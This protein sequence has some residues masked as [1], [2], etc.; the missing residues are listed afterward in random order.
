[1][2]PPHLLRVA[3]GPSRFGELIAALAAAGLRCGWLDLRAPDALPPDL[4]AAA[5]AGVLRAVA[6]GGGRSAAVKRLRGAPVVRDLVREHFH[7]C[8]TVLVR[9]EVDAPLLEAA[10]SGWSVTAAERAAR[11]LSTAALVAALR[12][13]RPFGVAAQNR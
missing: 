1:M 8:A 2:R 7:G 6:V 10:P 4:E 5:A 13:P 9:G 12:S 11:S 3:E